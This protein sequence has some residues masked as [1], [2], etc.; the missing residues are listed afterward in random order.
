MHDAEW[1]SC[2]MHLNASPTQRSFG[3]QVLNDG[4][5]LISTFSSKAFDPEKAR[6][7]L[8]QGFLYHAELVFDKIEN[9]QR[10]LGP[11]D[12][13]DRS[14]HGIHWQTESLKPMA[15]PIVEERPGI[16]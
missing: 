14:P 9:C 3:N 13:L 15:W 4:S 10:N 7:G 11:S 16:A 5:Y 2:E 6:D 12:V 8:W 1:F